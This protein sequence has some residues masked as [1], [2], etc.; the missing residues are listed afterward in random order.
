ML[1]FL[2]LPI[3]SSIYFAAPLAL[4]YTSVPNHYP[5][6]VSPTHQEKVLMRKKVV[7]SLPT[8]EKESLP[9]EL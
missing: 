8:K 1:F 7:G 9:P 2:F 6:V 3:Y 5:F 4:A